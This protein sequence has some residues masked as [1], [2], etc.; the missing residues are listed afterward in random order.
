MEILNHVPIS[1]HCWQGDDFH[2]LDEKGN[3]SGGI[4][5]TGS[6]PGRTRNA[7]ELHKDILEAM[8]LIPDKSKL[9]AFKLC[10]VER[11]KRRS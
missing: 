3:L 6:Y 9:T 2:A 4:A 1:V 7:E 5:V 8:R 11:K 10:A